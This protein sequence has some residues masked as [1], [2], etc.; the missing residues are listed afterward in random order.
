MKATNNDTLDY[1]KIK[2]IIYCPNGYY[3]S[4]S[5]WNDAGYAFRSRY[6]QQYENRGIAGEWIGKNSTDEWQYLGMDDEELSKKL[7]LERGVL[8][9]WDYEYITL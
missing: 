1:T 3:G 8:P 5:L 4:E 6:Q 9:V 2:T 7:G